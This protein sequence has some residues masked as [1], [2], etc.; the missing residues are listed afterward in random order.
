MTKEVLTPNLSNNI[1]W[2][3]YFGPYSLNRLVGAG[4][5]SWQK[6]DFSE[7]IPSNFFDITL[8]KSERSG[9]LEKS[10]C[11]LNGRLFP[12]KIDPTSP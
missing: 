10:G 7:S 12:Q 8:E 5:Q 4:C 3:L 11:R 6:C 1:F 9:T 2:A